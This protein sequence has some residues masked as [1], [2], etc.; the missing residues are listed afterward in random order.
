MSETRVNGDVLTAHQDLHSA[1]GALRGEH[2]GRSRNPVIKVADHQQFTATGTYSDNSTQNI[3]SQVSWASSASSVATINSAGLATGVNGGSSTISATQ[4]SI[5]GSAALTVQSAPLTIT[6]TALPG[7]SVGAAY[8][9]TVT[10][11]GGTQP[12]AWSIS[13]G[14]LPGGLTLSATTGA[15]TGTPTVSGTFSFT[16][17]VADSATPAMIASKGLSIA[18]AGGGTP[19]SVTSTTPASGATGVI[20]ST[21]VS[22]TFNSTLNAATV[23]SS[24][25][26]L[27]DSSNTAVSGSYNV[28]GNTATLTPGAVLAASTTYTATLTTGIKDV[29]G[30]AL[31]ADFTWSFTTGGSG[32]TT[33]FLAPSSNAPVTTGAGDNNGFETTPANAYAGDGLFAVDANSGTNSSAA[34]TNTGK[35]KH[36]FYTFNVSVPAGASIR[37][38]EVQ[39][40]AKVNSTANTPKMCAQLSWDGGATWTAAQSTATLTTTTATY[41]L[42]DAANNWGRTW[43]VADFS[44]SAFR[45]RIIDVA[46][47]TARTF[48]LD[49]L[50]L[51]VTYQ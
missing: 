45:V 21:T 51:R 43:G 5:S 27:K 22:A 35:D 41:T 23:T 48:S 6:T 50:A 42:G 8:S 32:T 39:L 49:A 7:G 38:I 3:T 14:T 33:G 12:Y 19:L 11:S 29:N 25:F 44:N 9:A 47:S 37:G 13:S 36:D 26:T 4:G 30:S 28:S 40:N 24:T 17:Q 20:V 10:A 16:V 18:I 1:Q 31:A 34:C 15:I 46:G 2:P